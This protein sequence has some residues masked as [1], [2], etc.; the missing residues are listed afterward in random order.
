MGDRSVTAVVVNYL[1]GDDLAKCLGGLLADQEF[2]DRV[3]VFDNGSDDDS[4]Q[5]AKEAGATDGRVELVR[6]DVNLG[7]AAAVNQVLPSV[8]TQYLAV[9]NPDATPQPGWLE[10][11]V[12]T[13]DS[14]ADVGVACPLVL[15]EQTGEVNSAGQHVHVTGLGF[16]RLL[17][18]DPEQVEQI[19]HE[20][21]GLHGVAFLIRTETLNHLGGWDRTG[22]L[23]H[24]DVALS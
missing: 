12:E 23:Y 16:N 14:N 18:A 6:S 5:A 1:S 8:K 9:L 10:P 24:E 17:H 19:R 4:A 2:V 13:L 3:V 21:G 22:F 20:V 15:I 7:L 11:L